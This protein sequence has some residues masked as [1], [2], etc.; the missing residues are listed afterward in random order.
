M[1]CTDCKEMS[2]FVPNNLEIHNVKTLPTQ[3][4][5]PQS[6]R[7]KRAWLHLNEGTPIEDVASY[8]F[9][10]SKKLGGPVPREKLLGSL[11]QPWRWGGHAPCKLRGTLLWSREHAF[12]MLASVFPVFK[13]A[14]F[15]SIHPSVRHRRPYHPRVETG[16]ARRG[17]A[18]R[19]GCRAMRSTRKPFSVA[20]SPASSCPFIS[21]LRP[22]C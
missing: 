12:L 1:S 8:F 15:G 18:G 22:C 7:I 20:C 2:E 21:C 3:S 16:T 14:H 13:I 4:R 5:Q 10:Q 11:C 9:Q 19:G 6:L 17:R